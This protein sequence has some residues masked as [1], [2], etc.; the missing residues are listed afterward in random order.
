MMTYVYVSEII[1]D[2]DICEQNFLQESNYSPL[3]ALYLHATV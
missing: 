3:Y 1:A 2:W